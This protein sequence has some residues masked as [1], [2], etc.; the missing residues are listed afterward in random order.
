MFFYVVF[1]KS[2][3]NIINKLFIKLQQ[4][5]LC[6]NHTTVMGLYGGGVVLVGGGEG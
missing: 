1:T 4:E 2:Y 5:S 3:F 6:M